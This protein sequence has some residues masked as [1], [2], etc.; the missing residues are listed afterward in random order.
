MGTLYFLYTL[1]CF[2]CFF[3]LPFSFGYENDNIHTVIIGETI[4]FEL[5]Y[6]GCVCADFLLRQEE[7]SRYLNRTSFGEFSF[8]INATHSYDYDEIREISL[9]FFL[10][11]NAKPTF[12]ENILQQDFHIDESIK[13]SILPVDNYFSICSCEYE[14]DTYTFDLSLNIEFIPVKTIMMH[15]DPA[16]SI[17][18]A[19]FVSV[20]FSKQTFTEKIITVMS[21]FDVTKLKMAFGNTPETFSFDML[22]GKPLKAGHRLQIDACIISNVLKLF[23]S[24]LGQVD[25]QFFTVVFYVE[26]EQPKGIMMWIQILDYVNPEIVKPESTHF[27]F[28]DG[29]LSFKLDTSD[30]SQDYMFRIAGHDQNLDIVMTK[31][32]PAKF[33]KQ[34]DLMV[35]NSTVMQFN[36]QNTPSYINS[37]Y[38]AT[39]HTSFMLVPL[40][41]L[42]E[43]EDLFMTLFVHSTSS[44]SIVLSFTPH[45]ISEERMTLG[46]N[47]ITKGFELKLGEEVNVNFRSNEKL[48]A[49]QYVSLAVFLRFESRIVKDMNMI[50]M[51]YDSVDNSR[52]ISTGHRFFMLYCEI[53]PDDILRFKASVVSSFYG[54]SLQMSIYA[55]KN[56][57]PDLIVERMEQVVQSMDVMSGQA[58][59][60][61]IDR[62]GLSDQHVQ[63]DLSKE[64]GKIQT[65]LNVGSPAG[66]PTELCCLEQS[67]SSSMKVTRDLFLVGTPESLM[68]DGKVQ[69]TFQINIPPYTDEK[70]RYLY[71]GVMSMNDLKVDIITNVQAIAR[72]Q[73]KDANFSQPVPFPS[74]SWSRDDSLECTINAP[75]CRTPK[76]V[77]VYNLAAP[78][79]EKNAKVM[80]QN[81]LMIITLTQKSIGK[82]L[83]LNAMLHTKHSDPM[84]V[85]F[86][87]SRC[88][89]AEQGSQWADFSDFKCRCS[90]DEQSGQCTLRVRVCHLFKG[91]DVAYL[92]I[93][94]DMDD[95]E[96]PET[97]QQMS[98]MDFS[99]RIDVENIKVKPISSLKTTH[100][101]SL[102]PGEYRYA[103]FDPDTLRKLD[104]TSNLGKQY[105]FQVVV[106]NNLKSIEK[107][108]TMYIIIKEQT[109]DSTKGHVSFDPLGMCTGHK[110]SVESFV[111]SIGRYVCHDTETETENIHYLVYVYRPFTEHNFL[112][113]KVDFSLRIE[114]MVPT[115]LTFSNAMLQTLLA[116]SYMHYEV[117]SDVIQQYMEKGD[118]REM[119]IYFYN[120]F[121]PDARFDL[122]IGRRRFIGDMIPCQEY[123]DF[124][125][126]RNAQNASYVLPLDYL[127][128]GDTFNN[129]HFS[130]FR[131]ESL[132]AAG[133]Y[134]PQTVQYAIMV[135]EL[136]SETLKVGEP[137]KVRTS[138]KKAVRFDIGDVDLDQHQIV[139]F[140]FNRTTHMPYPVSI[141]V[142]LGNMPE[143]V[144]F[145]TLYIDKINMVGLDISACSLREKRSIYFQLDGHD[146]SV[147][148]QMRA[149]YM[150]HD[151]L[152]E[153]PFSG[154]LS[155]GITKY[156]RFPTYENRKEAFFSVSVKPIADVEA[157]FSVVL[158]WNVNTMATRTI[159]CG[160][161]DF[162]Q[163]RKTDAN[164][165]AIFQIASCRLPQTDGSIAIKVITDNENYHTRD[166]EVDVW[167]ERVD[168]D[169]YDVLF[170]NSKKNY[171]Y[172]DIQLPQ[173][174][175]NVLHLMRNVEDHQHYDALVLLGTSEEYIHVSASYEGVPIL[176]N[177]IG[178]CSSLFDDRFTKGLFLFNLGFASDFYLS[179]SSTDMNMRILAVMNGKLDDSGII[180]LE[181]LEAFTIQPEFYNWGVIRFEQMTTNE[182]HVLFRAQCDG[183]LQEDVISLSFNCDIYMVFKQ[184]SLLNLGFATL[185]EAADFRV[186][187]TD[188]QETDMKKHTYNIG[189]SRKTW[190]FLSVDFSQLN[191]FKFYIPLSENRPLTSLRFSDS[192]KVSKDM[193]FYI[194]DDAIQN[195][196]LV[197]GFKTGYS[198]DHCEVYR[199]ENRTID[200]IMMSQLDL[201]H[202]GIQDGGFYI[203]PSEPLLEPVSIQFQEVDDWIG[204][205]NDQIIIDSEIDTVKTFIYS[206]LNSKCTL[207]IN[208][209][210]SAKGILSLCSNRPDYR[211]I[212]FDVHGKHVSFADEIAYTAMVDAIS[213]NGGFI[214]LYN[215]ITDVELA[216]NCSDYKM[217]PNSSLKDAGMYLYKF[218][219][220]DHTQDML[221]IL[222]FSNWYCGSASLYLLKDVGLIPNISPFISFN[223]SMRHG[224]E[225]YQRT[226]LYSYLDTLPRYMSVNALSSYRFD[227]HYD[228]K[229]L[230]STP[231]KF[232]ESLVCNDSYAHGDECYFTVESHIDVYSVIFAVYDRMHTERISDVCLFGID[233]AEPVYELKRFLSKLDKKH[234]P[235]YDNSRMV[236]RP[237]KEYL[238]RHYLPFLDQSY[239]NGRVFV[240]ISRG[241]VFS[242]IRNYPEII[243]V[244][245][246]IQEFTVMY[247]FGNLFSIVVDGNNDNEDEQSDFI[248]ITVDG[249]QECIDSNVT[250]HE[251]FS[252]HIL[253][254]IHTLRKYQEKCSYIFRGNTEDIKNSF[255]VLLSV[256]I[257]QYDQPSA[258]MTLKIEYLR[259]EN[260]R[261]SFRPGQSHVVFIP[262]NKNGYSPLL[263][264]FDVLSGQ[265]DS[266]VFFG[267]P[268]STGSEQ[269]L[270]AHRSSESNSNVHTIFC[271][272]NDKK[273]YARRSEQYSDVYVV[274]E[275]CDLGH[276]DN[277]FCNVF[278]GRQHR[279]IT[280]LSLR[281]IV[282]TIIEETLFYSSVIPP[283]NAEN[284]D[285]LFSRH[286]FDLYTIDLSETPNVEDYILSVSVIGND[287]HSE[288]T[289]V[290]LHKTIVGTPI[291][292]QCRRGEYSGLENKNNGYLF[293]MPA[294]NQKSVYLTFFNFKK[295]RFWVAL[296][297]NPIH[298]ITFDTF[299]HIP[300]W[301]FIPTGYT[302]DFQM[303]ASPRSTVRF[304]VSIDELKKYMY[305]TPGCAVYKDLDGEN[306]HCSVALDINVSIV[307]VSVIEI[308]L[309]DVEENSMYPRTSHKSML[310][311]EN[312]RY[313]NTCST[314]RCSLHVSEGLI[315]DNHFKNGK[316]V[317]FYIQWLVT[318]KSAAPVID[319]ANFDVSIHTIQTTALTDSTVDLQDSE[320]ILLS[321]PF[322]DGYLV[323]Y[324]SAA[325]DQNIEFNIYTSIVEGDCTFM[326]PMTDQSDANNYLVIMPNQS[327]E[328][329]LLRIPAKVLNVQ[330]FVFNSIVEETIEYDTDMFVYSG[331]RD[332]STMS[333]AFRFL[334]AVFD[335]N[336]ELFAFVF[337][338]DTSDALRV[339]LGQRVRFYFEH[340]HEKGMIDAAD[341]S[342]I[343]M[344]EL[345][346]NL[347]NSE[348]DALQSMHSFVP[349]SSELLNS[350]GTR[351][352][353]FGSG[354]RQLS[355]S[356]KS[357]YSKDVSN[358]EFCSSYVDDREVRLLDTFDSNT[359]QTLD[360]EAKLRYNRFINF[361]KMHLSCASCQTK[362]Q[363]ALQQLS[364][365]LSFY[366]VYNSD[367]TGKKQ[368]SIDKQLCLNVENECSQF[369]EFG[370]P[371]LCSDT[372]FVEFK[373]KTVAVESIWI[374]TAIIGLIVSAFVG[375]IFA[376]VLSVLKRR[377]LKRAHDV[378]R[379]ISAETYEEPLLEDDDDD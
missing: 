193:I 235:H 265:F 287:A 170:S 297:H 143:D 199:L 172:S 111:N 226:Y 358:V 131:S 201:F 48:E 283:L 210:K 27:T 289:T 102:L 10:A 161:A 362:C 145:A 20:E 85:A 373:P 32:Q 165:T 270:K 68:K 252:S 218:P 361:L 122:V 41:Q 329:C 275:N 307:G 107:T 379:L 206:S 183:L 104:V 113:P 320:L 323:S 253:I 230:P 267:P 89:L 368:A 363:D 141:N 173:V 94:P 290:F 175:F 277:E 211:P 100:S 257:N 188:F 197:T 156:L 69:V 149:E 98:K 174:A 280:Q 353:F 245:N 234:N 357:V 82:N 215:M 296:I 23:E 16:H 337:N 19:S 212:K 279:N 222:S 65:F 53:E 338:E 204:K 93:F 306:N 246:Q 333:N 14:S 324:N 38:D 341:T 163:E 347:R 64:G 330:P 228:V 83:V 70:E 229:P 247:P 269:S 317:R 2:F 281:T 220:H 192:S 292:S 95:L 189:K 132:D 291:F 355:V 66:L 178:A 25:P 133:A 238:S 293:Y 124:I 185:S 262:K 152:D 304:S 12:K 101:F 47:A 180:S 71:L 203:F 73:Q 372:R 377:Q 72:I 130:V 134:V 88:S 236:W 346:D 116:N 268:S 58:I 191:Y 99:I 308:A 327:E 255:N 86:D 57:Y 42:T 340:L 305:Q 59:Q 75:R 162:D 208:T 364:C 76:G 345:L 168:Y 223:H 153:L 129:L 352:L 164:E 314:T 18:N 319:S 15:S 13:Y 298:P 39:P 266:T 216:L 166:F 80:D 242:V 312:R 21:G 343:K 295:Y 278:I 84:S 127:K 254:P 115:N 154:F 264:E 63:I 81:K 62:M 22:D 1:T 300:V 219:F 3:I 36:I 303:V 159:G 142:A 244:T 90:A 318:A 121:P 78:K 315:T 349:F 105:P 157:E 217:L 310:D 140:M 8:S 301:R 184:C 110:R 77:R 370:G 151:E 45:I 52:V 286:E 119:S 316:E 182:P 375:I 176:V 150:R 158:F 34:C 354:V 251:Y 28:L 6:D 118:K 96:F 336:F 169:Y 339:N 60:F 11:V 371:L 190:N 148:L 54:G 125:T 378:L 187:L 146:H 114:S 259:D 31:N 155:N 351:F 225:V 325:G 360:K 342:N 50:K 209:L 171:T 271:P 249:G 261:V 202:D 240:T 288:N 276:Q 302:R 272:F 334:P 274:L 67:S 205:R 55:E 103:F 74:D 232:E 51:Q 144:T 87:A 313:R 284:Y 40:T 4:D 294:D 35:N 322:S 243:S 231:V 348:T 282:P 109:K 299:P 117:T 7:V 79:L 309:F 198:S 108:E 365:S 43:E 263:L 200:Y 138:R 241:C 207:N 376:G 331:I 194:C 17:P 136:G 328:A 46:D 214:T 258:Q 350:Q 321:K 49:N 196:F 26:H 374:K 213:F 326:N 256:Y 227:F 30:R 106:Y 9:E 112:N 260:Q 97:A 128:N 61:R 224:K 369:L 195:I 44:D 239:V 137:R 233:I 29:S 33:R 181:P 126:T 167:I 92:H 237:D 186:T 37:A 139:Q 56:T 123:W 135:A 5:K 160:S 221:L 250:N 147:D 367:K 335:R 179:L 366:E 120:I 311:H 91:R 285:S 24:T 344:S 332:P 248:Q 273:D 356:S 359:A 177:G